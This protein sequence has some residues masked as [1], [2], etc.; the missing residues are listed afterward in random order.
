MKIGAKPKE[1]VKLGAEI[2]AFDKDEDHFLPEPEHPIEFIK[3]VLPLTEI[4]AQ[5]AEEA[6]ELAHAAHKLRRA[7]G[8]MN[9]TPVKPEEARAKIMEEYGDVLNC[10]MVLS[11]QPSENEYIQERREF[12]L[13]RWVSRLKEKRRDEQPAT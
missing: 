2:P 13:E 1:I 9:P 11:V 8:G 6:T 5:L 10:M 7:I 12:K 4:L 3:R